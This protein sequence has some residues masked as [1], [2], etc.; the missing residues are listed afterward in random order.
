M[1]NNYLQKGLWMN[2]VMLN[3]VKSHAF[4]PLPITISYTLG[5]LFIEAA[6]W[7]RFCIRDLK[8]SVNGPKW[9]KIERENLLCI[10]YMWVG[11]LDRISIDLRGWEAYQ[12]IRSVRYL[13]GQSMLIDW[14]HYS[15]YIRLR[16]TKNW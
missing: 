12:K 8:G 9:K 15:N 11:P 1:R 16:R 4:T 6:S 10:Y 13:F 3:S 14:W 5:L 7:E 2:D